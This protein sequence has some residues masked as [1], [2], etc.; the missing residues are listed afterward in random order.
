[1]ADGKTIII[2]SPQ[3]QQQQ[4]QQQQIL[5]R[6]SKDSMTQQIIR[7]PA[8]KVVASSTESTI[9]VSV[10]LTCPSASLTQR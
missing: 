10:L 7:I 8:S 1:M 4:Q 6:P 3:K 9:Q 2:G 5:I